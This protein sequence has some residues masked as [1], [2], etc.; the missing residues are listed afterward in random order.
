MNGIDDAVP[1]AALTAAFLFLAVAFPM[2]MAALF[3][4]ASRVAPATLCK[5]DLQCRFYGCYH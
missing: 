4:I 5:F 2:T 1:E 3:N